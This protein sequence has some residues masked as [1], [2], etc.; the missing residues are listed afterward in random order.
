MRKSKTQGMEMEDGNQ[1]AIPARERQPAN[2]TG[3]ESGYER[4]ARILAEHRDRGDAIEAMLEASG[5]QESDWLEFKAGMALLPKDQKKG[6]TPEDLYLD[7]ALSVAA[8]LNTRGGAFVIGVDDKSHNLVPLSTCDPRHVLEKEG[9]DAYLRKEVLDR[10]APSGHTIKSQGHQWRFSASLDPYIESRSIPFQGEKVIGLLVQPCLPGGEITV[11]WGPNE[12]VEFLPIRKLGEV[13]CVKRL[14]GHGEINSYLEWRRNGGRG[15]PAEAAELPLGTYST[16]DAPCEGRFVGRDAELEK[17]GGL[18]EKGKV[19]VITGGGGTGKSELVRQYAARHRE[20]YPG[21]MFQIDMGHVANWDEAFLCLLD[22]PSNTGVGVAECLEIGRAQE[23]G[24]FQEKERPTGEDVREALIRRAWQH[25]Q[26]LL[27]LDNVESCEDLFGDGEVKRRMFPAGLAEGAKIDVVATARVF[28]PSGGAAVQFPLGDLPLATAVELLLSQHPAGTAEE[29]AAAEQVARLLECRALFLRCVP[30][31]IGAKKCRP[32]RLICRSYAS[33]AKALE[34][35]SLSAIRGTGKVDERHLPETL[36]KLT[37]D[38]LAGWGGL[39]EGAVHLVRLAAHFPA[40]GFPRHVLRRLWDAE[41]FPGTGEEGLTPDEAFEFVL[42]ACQ[43]HNIFQ[44]T[45]PVRIHRLDREAILH[46]PESDGPEL[47]RA[48]GRALSDYLGASPEIWLSLAAFPDIVRQI[49]PAVANGRLYAGLLSENPALAKLC[50]WEAFDCGDWALLLARQPQFGNSCPWE[51]LVEDLDGED[52]AKLLETSP[53]FADKCPWDRVKRGCWAALIS[54]QPQFSDRCPWDE[55][56]DWDWLLV[57][58]NQPQFA[59]WCRWEKLDRLDW[60]ALLRSCPQFADLCPREMLPA[61]GGTR[62]PS[63]QSPRADADAGE[64]PEGGDG[65]VFFCK[66]PQSVE[67]PPR[68]MMTGRDWADLLSRAPQFADTCPWEKLD[69]KDWAKV[70][71]KQPQMAVMCPWEKLDG[72]DWAHL[73][74]YQP[75]FE[76]KCPW[77]DL[78]G[79]AWVELLGVSLRFVG[80]C[81]WKMLD[82]GLTGLLAAHPQLANRCAWREL[83]GLAWASLLRDSPQFADKCPWD[84]FDGDDWVCLLP[85]AEEKCPWERLESRHWARV[86]GYWPEYA[87]KCPW[88]Q[89]TTDLGGEDWAMLISEQPQFADKCPWEKLDGKDWARLLCAQPRFADRCPWEK[90]GEDDFRDLVARQPQ[91][92]GRRMNGDRETPPGG[93]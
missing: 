70:L 79:L 19:P 86:L 18:L 31:I 80:Q 21:G 88:K 48:V 45:D 2:A 30:A 59:K 56:D 5:G 6:N 55:L 74:G 60:E 20:D 72:R 32:G 28:E 44:S 93:G 66:T 26:V 92:A 67:R 77:K 33:L 62:M 73:L 17:V 4:A 36:W 76:G 15:G 10:I 75:Q 12:M 71:Q 84:T 49:P 11:D 41:V 14:K 46:D 42:D 3:L 91:F 43:A 16:V 23:K 83:N 53:Q 35:D 34:K 47:A 22:R 89:L 25:G 81:P 87:D 29:R 8:M 65:A 7:Y 1:T 37:R 63:G 50:P 9:W 58:R 61:A 40:E 52:W 38:T 24:Q 39:G 90:M 78:N 64:K 69:G 57:L 68:E 27:V 82:F 13:G 54:K 85:W 51:K